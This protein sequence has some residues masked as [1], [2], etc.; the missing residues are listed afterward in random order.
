[1]VDFIYAHDLDGVDFDWEYP[2]A[3]DIPGIP[4]GGLQEGQDYLEFLKIV[5][6]MLPDKSVSIAAPASYWYLKGYPIAEIGE[7]VD[8]M[9]YMIYD[10]HGQVILSNF[11]NREEAY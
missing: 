4:A 1:M 8:Y 5:K 2:V 10:L 11:S 9:V 7:V 6:A 3:P